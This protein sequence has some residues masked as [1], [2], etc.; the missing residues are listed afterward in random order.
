MVV[1]IRWQPPVAA[2]SY[3]IGTTPRTA[4]L[5]PCFRSGGAIR[6]FRNGWNE[7]VERFA[8]EAIAASLQQLE[9]LSR[10]PI[11]SLRHS[12]IVLSHKGD[13]WL[14]EA[15]RER[16]WSAFRVPILEQVIGKRG[17]LLA[18]DCEAH[19]GL[20]IE[21]GRLE[22]DKQDLDTSACSCGRKSPRLVSTP[23]TELAY[24][25]AAYAR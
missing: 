18:T 23:R 7:E 5:V 20:H 24:R 3:P 21:S 8:P 4:V 15:G 10:N 6:V 16:L 12:V 9:Q 17:E 2:F 14:T 1:R 13:S 22:I 25:V 19:G 11:P